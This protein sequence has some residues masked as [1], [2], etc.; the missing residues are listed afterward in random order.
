MPAIQCCFTVARFVIA[1][2]VAF[3]D[4]RVLVPS[5][6][7]FAATFFANASFLALCF[8]ELSVAAFFAFFDFA[9][10][11][12]EDVFVVFSGAAL[13][14]VDVIFGADAVVDSAGNNAAHTPTNAKRIHLFN[15]IT[16]SCFDESQNRA[17]KHHA[18]VC[19]SDPEIVPLRVKS[20]CVKIVIR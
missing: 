12:T 10:F 6:L 8:L 14:E 16:I 11:I 5:F 2:L 19:L 4:D 15:S 13:V 7:C 20:P 3:F 17:C 9:A 1:R 18:A